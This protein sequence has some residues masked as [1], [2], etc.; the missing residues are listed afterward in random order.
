MPELPAY[1][2]KENKD[3]DQEKGRFVKNIIVWKHV[4]P[5]G[6]SYFNQA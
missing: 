3:E 4:H 2:Q 5:V 6:K 1:D